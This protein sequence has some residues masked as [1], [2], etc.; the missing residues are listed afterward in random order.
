MRMCSRANLWLFAISYHFYYNN[1]PRGQR[2]DIEWVTTTIYIYVSV[3]SKSHQS[4][5]E[6]H[7]PK[8]SKGWYLWT[9]AECSIALL[10]NCTILYNTH[11]WKC[12]CFQIFAS[13][14]S[15][16]NKIYYHKNIK[17]IICNLIWEYFSHHFSNEIA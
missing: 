9:S 11:W 4:D 7:K 12:I 5:T 10:L 16:F 2:S 3:R 1:F 8:S 14:S 15:A 6:Q 13:F 17:W